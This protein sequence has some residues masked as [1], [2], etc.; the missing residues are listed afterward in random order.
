MVPSSTVLTVSPLDVVVLVPFQPYTGH[1]VEPQYRNTLGSRFYPHIM[2]GYGE[3]ARFVGRDLMF[4]GAAQPT[5]GDPREP[6]EFPVHRSLTAVALAT[7]L[8][9]AGLR[10]SVLDPG[11]QEIRWWR[12]QLEALA[13]RRPRC[14]GISTTFVLGGRWLRALCAVVRHVLPDAAVILGGYYYTSDAADFLSM[15]ADVFCIGAGE[16]RFERIVEA[17]R[18]RRPL[19]AIPGLYL[20]RADGTLRHTGRAEEP[21]LATLTPPDWTLADRITPP[22]SHRDDFL[23]VGVET[24]RGCVFKCEFC[25]YRTLAPPNLLDVDLAVERILATRVVPR[26]VLRLTD[27]TATFPHDRWERLME[28]LA[29]R[30]GSPH[31]LWVYARVSDIRERTAALMARAGVREVFIGQESGDQRVLG[32]M[33]KGTHV[34]QVRPA[35]EAIQ[36]FLER[37]GG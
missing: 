37:R 11:Q 3:F 9:R 26:A 10:W 20:R 22:R 12:K 31:P 35:L 7:L 30:G 8:E 29:E 6:V 1:G 15:D 19:D 13:P 4:R 24:Q 5:F 14:V 17:L 25:T 18:D 23:D 32:L 16:G 21:P 33:R 27:S 2:E 34:R 28:R 36:R